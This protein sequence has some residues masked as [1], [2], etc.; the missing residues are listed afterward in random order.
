MPCIWLKNGTI[1]NIKES[2]FQD[3]DFVKFLRTL[4]L[5]VTD[6]SEP[7]LDFVDEDHPEDEDPI[8]PSESGE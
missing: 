7:H 1:L 2:A 8:G 5:Q 4:D 3:P 6:R